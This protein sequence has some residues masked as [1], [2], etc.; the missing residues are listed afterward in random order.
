[1]ASIFCIYKT[2]KRGNGEVL[3]N[4]DNQTES[5]VAPFSIGGG[6]CIGGVHRFPKGAAKEQKTQFEIIGHL[7][8]V[9]ITSSDLHFYRT[10]VHMGSDYWVAYLSIYERFLKPFEDYQCCQC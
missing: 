3:H 8:S 6:R 7:V 4:V 9:I 1:M 10:H 5:A 2:L